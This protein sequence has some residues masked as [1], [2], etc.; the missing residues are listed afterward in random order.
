VVAVRWY[1]RYGLSYP[2]VQELRAERGAE[3]DHITVLR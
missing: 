3:V 2:K 1:V